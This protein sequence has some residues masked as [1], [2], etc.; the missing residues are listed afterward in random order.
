MGSQG[1]WEGERTGEG[2]G[3]RK[4]TSW[5]TRRGGRVLIMTAESECASVSG[6]LFY[7]HT[8]KG[9]ID[10][11]RPTA[12][13]IRHGQ[14]R[15]RPRLHR[16]KLPILGA[17]CRDLEGFIRPPR[18]N[19]ASETAEELVWWRR[20]RDARENEDNKREGRTTCGHGA[21]S[22]WRSRPAVHEYVRNTA[23][24]AGA[25]ATVGRAAERVVGPNPV[26]CDPRVGNLFAVT[27]YA[28]I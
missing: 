10:I 14:P 20:L 17:V 3:E 25:G 24:W 15:C 4:Q 8:F 1:I 27:A 23:A 13:N 2:G 6:E 5:G 16:T 22:A 26:G 11:N 21:S 12:I 7:S 28:G 9:G 19:C 18:T